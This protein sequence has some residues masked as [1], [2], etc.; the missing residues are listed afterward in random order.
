MTINLDELNLRI[1]EGL[2]ERPTE[3]YK[4]LAARLKVDQRTVAKRIAA[5]KKEGALAF[6]TRIDWAKLGFQA[7]GFVSATTAV[8]EKQTEKLEEFIRADPRIIEAFQTVGSHE[9]L[10]RVQEVDLPRLRDSVLR[11]LE[12]LTSNLSTNLVTSNFKRKGDARLV[13]YFR[14]MKFPR[15]SASS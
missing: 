7:S 4:G 14:E 13:K 1:I 6:E 10:I 9:Y 12:P 8:G 3:S 5:L 2:L 11:D 15:S